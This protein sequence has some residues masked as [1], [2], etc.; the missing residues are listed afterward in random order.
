MYICLEGIDGSG[1]STQN[2]LLAKW[3]ESC[4]Y[5]VLKVY[6]PTHSPVGELIRQMLKD[7]AATDT[8]FQQMLALLFAADR[9]L[10]Q[11][12]I[13]FADKKNNI[14]LSD[15]CLYSSLVYQSDGDWIAQ[16]NQH[17]RRPDLLIIL[18]VDVE[19][20][21]QRC[22]RIDSFE[23]RDFL[24]KIRNRY[25]KLADEENFP[26]VNASAGINKIQSD[27]RKIISSHLGMCI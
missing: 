23:T 25:L 21:L 17:I 12:K 10:L 16:I 27:L 2:D 19:I 7:E 8:L 9:T 15:R 6:E 22:D 3:L 11:K 24:E 18:D 26:V 20:A 5:S 1:K 14:V 4:G 13:I